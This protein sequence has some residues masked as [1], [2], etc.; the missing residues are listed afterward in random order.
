MLHELVIQA[1][2]LVD[3]AQNRGLV[4]VV[5]DGEQRGEAGADLRQRRAFAPQQADAEGVERRDGGSVARLAG[6]QGS[7]ALAHLAGGLVGEGDGQDGPSRNLVGADQV[8]D[9]V[10]DHAGLA[11]AGAGQDQ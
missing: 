8:G 1:E 3:G 9:A 2:L 6:D 4:V 11:A 5:V 7:D 10:R